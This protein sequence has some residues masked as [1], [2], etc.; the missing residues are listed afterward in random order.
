M[1]SYNYHVDTRSF[2]IHWP[3][4]PYKC[5][6]CPFVAIAGHDA[7]MEQYHNALNKELDV[8][9]EKVPL[10]QPLDTI[11]IG[12]GTPSTYPDNL[13]LDT[14]G[15]LR[16]W[17]LI[18]PTTEITIEVNPGTVRKEQLP[19]W[20]EAGINRLSIGVQSLN[21][22][23]LKDLNRQQSNEDVFALLEH[24]SHYF[25]SI[26]VDLILGLPSISDQ[27]W[28][29]LLAAVVQWPIKHVSV[30]FLTVHEG[31]ALYFRVK[32]NAVILPADDAMVDLYQWTIS[33]LHEHGFIQYETSNFAKE[34]FDCRHNQVYWEYKPYKAF[35]LGACAFD[36]TTRF[37]NEKNLMTY[38][39]AIEAGNE[40]TVFAEE[41]TEEQ[42]KL[43]KL[44]L[45][46]RQMR[47]GV[48]LEELFEGR[49]D[50]Q[51]LALVNYI[52]SMCDKG[53]VK[54]V[55][56]RL[57]LTSLGISVENEIIVNLS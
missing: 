10:H 8:Y 6:F 26:S 44:M 9:M 55:N 54:E 35:G 46:M 12:G 47:K 50:E 18:Q 40:V 3:F 51:R 13:L 30:Y 42:R 36:G 22:K 57:F 53:L 4:C 25:S 34:G 16:R 38:M 32:R 33:F 5:H 17:N 19:L 11:F 14:F 56:N 2:Y 41:L 27:E 1:L 48:L 20:K 45:G 37:Q 49:S 21:N 23:V 15:K 43:E 29:D 39:Q 31:T 24:A 7:Y 28:K 52:N